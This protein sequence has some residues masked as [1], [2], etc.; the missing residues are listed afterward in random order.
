LQIA[1]VGAGIAGLAAAAALRR[2]GIQVQLYEQAQQ[3]ARVGAGIQITPNGMKLL[4]GLGIGDRLRRAG[5]AP[6]VTHHRAWDSA[7]VS[8]LHPMGAATE[9]RYGAPD[10]M[11]HRA[12]LHA[13][14]ASLLPQES[15]HF[16]KKLAGI[17]RAGSRLELRF[18]DN[19]RVQADAVIGADGIHSV[20]RDLL[21][22]A[23]QLHFT[24]QVA[25]RA[26]FPT[27]LLG[28]AE[29]DDRV[30]WWGPDRH[31]VSYMMDRRREEIYFMAS[32]P[33]PDFVDE[34]WSAPGD[35]KVLRAAYEGFHPRATV[36][37]EA[38]PAVRKWALI[39][40]G[41]IKSWTAD[42]V[43]LIGDA[44]HP[45]LPYMAQGASSSMEDGV[46]LARCFEALGGG[47]MNAVFRMCE[48]NRKQRTSEFQRGSQRNDWMKTTAGIDWV[49]EYDAWTVPLTQA[50]QEAAEIPSLRS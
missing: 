34:S 24:G 36:L 45:M 22:G 46:V 2:V 35:L 49:Y 6:E 27:R 12:D 1:I 48:A 25:Y 47:D 23:E 11:M 13:A 28:D 30:K 41:P 16:N 10:L 50:P 43:L 15:I 19:S 14:L 29:V 18:F 26:V 7:E 39:E 42:S 38:C 20:V 9:Q 5:F 33:E 17:D 21:F 37:L 3:F 40:R 31:L 32:T 44:C 8:Y 4:Y